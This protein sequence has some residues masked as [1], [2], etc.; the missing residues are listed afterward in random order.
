M[1]LARRLAAATA[2]LAALAGAH[3]AAAP[4]RADR[5]LLAQLAREAGAVTSPPGPSAQEYIA[6]VVRRVAEAVL[7]WLLPSGKGLESAFELLST[8]ARILAWT[9]VAA[10]IFLLVRRLV[11][12][13]IRRSRGASGEAGE[14][15]LEVA[16][17]PQHDPETWLRRFREALE[18]GDLDAAMQALWMWA[19]LRLAGPELDAAWTSSELLAHAGRRD[20]RAVFGRLDAWR[21]GPQ[22]PESGRL[23]RLAAELV[24][25]TG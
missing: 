21:Y 9:L 11:A 4:A 2:C 18:A 25:V 12:G 13:W 20:L 7:D 5:E 6:M 8:L 19:G 10:A 3:P 22:R 23:E 16:A 15:G 24:E 1:R 14:T 17:R